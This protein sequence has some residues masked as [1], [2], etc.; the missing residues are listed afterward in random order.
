MNMKV[1]VLIG[2]TCCLLL[3]GVCHQSMSVKEKPND[4]PSNDISF[5]A[6]KTNVDQPTTDSKNKKIIIQKESD[7]KYD[8]YNEPTE[9][10]QP[11]VVENKPQEQIK[12]Q[13]K[14]KTIPPKES[15]VTSPPTKKEESTIS[16]PQIEETPKKL[17]VPKEESKD[18][19]VPKEPAIE[20]FDVEPI[21]ASAKNYAVSIG[22]ILD[23]S[24]TECWDN[25]ISAN[26][27]IKDVLG[28]IQSR[29]NRY[30]N[31]EGFTGVWIWSEKISDTDYNIYIGYY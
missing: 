21:I 2:M 19:N 31:I 18:P 10:I 28:D 26:A 1:K 15:E 27:G 30:K 25:P 29:L 6:G 5:S 23:S 7:I 13:S 24:A 20:E 9:D 11:S 16:T 3:L 14:P 12:Q 4:E 22:L 8:S 17:N